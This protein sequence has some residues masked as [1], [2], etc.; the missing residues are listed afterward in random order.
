M[1]SLNEKVQI[2]VGYNRG[3][4]AKVIGI[5]NDFLVLSHKGHTLTYQP[6]EVKRI[7]KA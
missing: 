2:M 6:Q 1:F 3:K 4:T 7:D 5:T